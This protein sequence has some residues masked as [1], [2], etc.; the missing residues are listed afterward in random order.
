MKR[1]HLTLMLTPLLDM[2]I[3]IVFLQLVQAN[4]FLNEQVV[5]REEA[6]DLRRTA[7]RQR[8]EATMAREEAGSEIARLDDIVAQ[9]KLLVSELE[10]ENEQL[11]ALNVEHERV[12]TDM[13]KAIE[14]LGDLF[15]SLFDVPEDLLEQ[16]IKGIEEDD[17]ARKVKEF[18][19]Q[20]DRA[21]P[22]QAVRFAR[23]MNELL[24]RA[25]FWDVYVDAGNV[26]SFSTPEGLM[27]EGFVPASPE[28][29]RNRLH[30]AMGRTRD[31]PR[32]VIIIVSCHPASKHEVVEWVR[33]AMV[34]VG[35]AIEASRRGTSF[36]VTDFG[37]SEERP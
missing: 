34:Y 17:E 27:L 12:A 16:V 4:A 11:K 18:L 25:E 23:Q 15:K 14:E 24:K 36:V 2:L 8:D 31:G 29:V 13:A 5:L 1:R 35:H 32:L 9:Q 21:S 30:E 7:D 33:K 19:V 6:E 37:I 26:V 28:S 3:I 22:A 20:M 10:E